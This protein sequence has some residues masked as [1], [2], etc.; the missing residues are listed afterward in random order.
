[1]TYTDAQIAQVCHE[2]NRTRQT[3][4]VVSGDKSIPVSQPW[5]SLTDLDREGIIAGVRGVID[6]K[7]L[8][9]SHEAWCEHKRALGRKYGPGQERDR[10]HTR[11]C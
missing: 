1:M 7:T 4:H 9:Q 5:W 6:G 2:A 8:E 11:A 10:A 3:L